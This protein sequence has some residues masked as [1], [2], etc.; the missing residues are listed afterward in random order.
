ME[1]FGTKERTAGLIL[2]L[3][4]V[5]KKDAISSEFG[6]DTLWWSVDCDADDDALR[7]LVADDDAIDSS[8]LLFLV[9]GAVKSI[10]LIGR[11]GI[12]FWKAGMIH[13]HVCCVQVGWPIILT[14]VSK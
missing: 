7:E 12:S 9:L 3:E 11:Y 5:S 13:W 4:S 1:Y 6:E 8:I 10:S 2:H 14:F